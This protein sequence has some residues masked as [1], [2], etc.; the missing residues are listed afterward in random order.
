MESKE[1][2]ELLDEWTKDV[3]A[4]GKWF[5][6]IR[7]EKASSEQIIA[8]YQHI[9]N[10]WFEHRDLFPNKG[11][12]KMVRRLFI[13]HAQR[14]LAR[15][16]GVWDMLPADL[17]KEIL[18][19]ADQGWISY[20]EEISKLWRR[21]LLW[22]A[23]QAG[24]EGLKDKLPCYVDEKLK[25]VFHRH[26]ATGVV[27][28]DDGGVEVLLFDPL[29]FYRD[30]KRSDAELAVKDWGKCFYPDYV[31]GLPTL[32]MCRFVNGK[33]SEKVTDCHLKAMPA[34]SVLHAPELPIVLHECNEPEPAGA[35]TTAENL[36]V[37]IFMSRE[38]FEDINPVIKLLSGFILD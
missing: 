33:L 26:Q 31:V 1:F 20:N 13:K 9:V 12:Y 7:N 5:F 6:R 18:H 23:V 16:C 3:K 14:V 4:V 38:R 22:K 29:R 34:N 28:L 24:Y 11:T 8:V 32:E 2:R 21:Y 19:K 10:M 27:R 37:S 15:S 30:S 17:C 36:Y 25:L 35:N